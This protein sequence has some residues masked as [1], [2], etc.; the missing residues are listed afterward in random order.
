M[1][2]K[3]EATETIDRRIDNAFRL[4]NR[5]VD[6]ILRDE[7]VNFSHGERS[8]FIGMFLGNSLEDDK[9]ERWILKPVMQDINRTLQEKFKGKQP[10]REDIQRF[11]SEEMGFENF[12]VDYMYI[13][14]DMYGISA[15]FRV[16]FEFQVGVTKLMNY[17]RIIVGGSD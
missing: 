2:T 6:F 13:E 12:H 5:V 11:I 8:D 10:T 7:K 17:V 3:E 16:T 1:I 15:S 4:K 14:G 9:Y